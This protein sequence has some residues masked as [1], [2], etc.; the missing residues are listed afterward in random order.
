MWKCLTRLSKQGSFPTIVAKDDAEI[1]YKLISDN[2]RSTEV[3]SYQCD[4][5][6]I[7]FIEMLINVLA[8]C[9]KDNTKIEIER[10]ISYAHTLLVRNIYH[11]GWIKKQ[12][13]TKGKGWTRCEKR[14]FE[15]RGHYLYYYKDESEN[16]F[17]N[18][19]N[20]FDSKCEI[21]KDRRKVIICDDQHSKKLLKLLCNTNEDLLVLKTKIRQAKSG[22]D[23]LPLLREQHGGQKSNAEEND[24]NITNKPN[25]LRPQ[26]R[27]N[28][29]H[30]LDIHN[31]RMQALFHR[32][33]LDEDG[34]I[35][36]S[37]FK[38]FVEQC[39]LKIEEKYIKDIF[40]SI[41][42]DNSNDIEY[43]ELCRYF[44]GIVLRDWDDVK[45]NYLIELKRSM[46][47]AGCAEGI[48]F[49]WLT[50]LSDEKVRS[51]RMKTLVNKLMEIVNSKPVDMSE[52]DLKKLKSFINMLDRE[53][54]QSEGDIKVLAEVL[55]SKH[56]KE[57]YRHSDLD[58]LANSI[59]ERW[60]CFVNFKRR[61]AE[62]EVVMDSE[63]TIV[64]DVV[65]GEYNLLELVFISEL[66]PCVPKHAEIE[67]PTWTSGCNGKEGTLV[68]PNDASNRIP[69]ESLSTTQMLM[70]YNCKLADSDNN[71]HLVYRH[72]I[73]DFRYCRTYSD[74][75][76]QVG[77][78]LE[79]HNFDHLDCPLDD[80]SGYIVL[81]KFV[82]HVL[83]VT[84]FKIPKHHVLYIPSNCIHSNDYFEGKW[85]TMLSDKPIDIVKLVKPGPDATDN[86]FCFT[87]E[88]TD[89]DI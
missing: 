47:T 82:E 62:G 58:Q 27:Y 56:I 83:H 89:S 15:L 12:T 72:M 68:F 6:G 41:D 3:Y 67:S 18:A 30:I 71:V 49:E 55:F 75:V 43:Q 40:K 59:L 4:G 2:V 42:T 32:I 61:N 73:Q 88:Q 25:I 10:S 78:G 76:R 80:E 8:K 50:K 14:W 9:Y 54:K 65:P 69:V 31:K 79:R 1:L 74:H 86:K 52:E 37:E 11:V 20:I 85:R 48:N 36:Y 57:V 26:G 84:A 19:F 13:N 24:D 45:D 44:E 28:I 7:S 35:Q 51:V 66:P 21:P 38:Q 22:R 60:K 53:T 34:Y 70:Y 29:K 16:C 33:D 23:V 77:G 39:N 64:N 87:F 63:S 46:A 81:A 17:C 5:D